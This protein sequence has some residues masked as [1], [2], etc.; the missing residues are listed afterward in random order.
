MFE[1]KESNNPQKTIK[2]NNFQKQKVLFLLKKSAPGK[3]TKEGYN[4]YKPANQK[5]YANSMNILISSAGKCDYFGCVNPVYYVFKS[6]ENENI[7]F[8]FNMNQSKGIS[9]NR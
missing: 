4:Q 5:N 3:N 1:T 7:D 2:F 6:K 9:P 8:L